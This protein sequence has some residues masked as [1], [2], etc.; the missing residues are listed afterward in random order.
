MVGEI[1]STDFWAGF[2]RG[3]DLYGQIAKVQDSKPVIAIF[4]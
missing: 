1:S 4:D 2:I 3:L